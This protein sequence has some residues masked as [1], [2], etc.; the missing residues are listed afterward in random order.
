MKSIFPLLLAVPGLLVPASVLSQPAETEFPGVT[1]EVIELRQSN[2]VLRLAVKLVNSGAEDANP[3][4]F[5]PERFALVDVESM[6]K[7]LPIKDADGLYLAGP[8]RDVTGSGDFEPHIPAGYTTIWWV[9]FEPVE[10]GTV[11]NVEVPYMFPFENVPVTEG[12]SDVFAANTARTTPLG[13]MATLV[14]ANRANGVLTVR[15]RL[16]AEAGAEVDI[17]SYF[18][19]KD[20]SILD[21]AGKRKYPLLRDAAGGFQAQPIG[22]DV[23]G[24]SFIH[25]WDRT[26]L[27]SLSFPAPPDDV[28]SVDLIL[29]EFLP[30]ASVAIAGTGGASAGEA[31]GMAAAGT[32]LGLEGA[33]QELGAEV[34]DTEIRIDLS[35]DVL[36]D[37]DSA[38]L[39]SEAEPSL[40]QVATVLKEHPAASVRIEGHTDGVGPDAYNQT[41]S[42]SRAESVKQWLVSKGQVDGAHVTTRGWGESKPV[43]QNTKP[44]GSDDPE[45]RAKNRRVEIV[46]QRGT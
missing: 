5:S 44:D 36:F 38:D 35:A 3:Y 24:G 19:F 46:V 14:S 23:G 4:S 13:G 1:A 25:H 8:L 33:L 28:R 7:H 40:L 42:E 6:Q 34:T 37:F 12:A 39:K 10:P 22:T 9:Y 2:G 11:V 45:G 15:L 16:A 41:L 32:T 43:A 27:V 17:D 18:L 31:G 30:M 21:T 26:T 20:V 29:P